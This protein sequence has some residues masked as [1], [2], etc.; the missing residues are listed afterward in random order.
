MTDDKIQG[1]VR[2]NVKDIEWIKGQV[3]DMMEEMRY[4]EKMEP[5]TRCVESN[6]VTEGCEEREGE[7]LMEHSFER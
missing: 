5:L 3:E 2:Q 4:Y 7:M 6:I 1:L